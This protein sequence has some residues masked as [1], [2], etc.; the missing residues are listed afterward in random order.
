MEHFPSSQGSSQRSQ[1]ERRNVHRPE[2]YYAEGSVGASDKDERNIKLIAIEQYARKLG[3]ANIF[4]VAE[5]S[6]QNG[7]YHKVADFVDTC[8]LTRIYASYA[9]RR[10]QQARKLSLAVQR[11]LCQPAVDIYLLEWQDLMK[12]LTTFKQAL[13]TFSPEYVA[14]FNIESLYRRMV[15]TALC[16]VGLLCSLTPD[17]DSRT[18]S[19]DVTDSTV[20]AGEAQVD[21]AAPPQHR[22]IATAISIIA[23][24]RSQQFNAMQG[25][26]GYYLFACRVPKRVIST[27]NKLG[28][29]PSYSGLLAV[30]KATAEAALVDL[31]QV[32]LNNKGIMI[33]YDNLSYL[34]NK[35]DLRINNFTRVV[36]HTCGYTLIPHKSQSRPMFD[37]SAL[38]YHRIDEVGHSDIMPDIDAAKDILAGTKHMIC[39]A[40]LVFGKGRGKDV[41]LPDTFDFPMR[42]RLDRRARPKILTFPTYPLNEGIIGELTELIYR[43]ADD[44]GMTIEQREKTCQLFKGDLKTV[45][46]GNRYDQPLGEQLIHRQVSFCASLNSFGKRLDFVE[47]SASLFHLGIH[48]LSVV[49]NIHYGDGDTP[50]SLVSW[51]KH[52][53]RDNRQMWNE[54]QALVKQYQVCCDLVDHLLS[55]YLITWLTCRLEMQSVTELA[56]RLGRRPAST[57]SHSQDKL[58]AAIEGLSHGLTNYRHV[59]A[60]RSVS[61]DEQD[62]AYENAILFMQQAMVIRIFLY[63]C[64]IGDSGVVVDC[65]SVFAAWFQATGKYNYARETIHLKACLTKLWTVEFREFWLDTCLIN[66]SGKR[67]GWMPCDFFGEYVVRE[68]KAMM[69]NDTGEVNDRFL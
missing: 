34:A 30:I 4:K 20:T 3:F 1:E 64:R 42:R 10:K 12:E 43:V 62:K 47:S 33:F 52:L 40:L 36:V 9:S 53:R 7:D 32:C 6:A 55:G 57:D 15:D 58:S 13:S 46:Q 69:H 26:I 38:T 59:R 23:N 45:L 65:I 18:E 41:R 49:F 14:E 39:K 2:N 25:R 51:I 35:R 19:T 21:S 44:V 31:R 22:Y 17:R 60:L 66:P 63:A 68:V 24:L 29:C 5:A 50:P 56:D 67:E 37:R 48:A 28:L 11:M 8:G 54:K 16:F 27:F 61:N